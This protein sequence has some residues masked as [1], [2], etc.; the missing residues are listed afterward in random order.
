MKRRTLVLVGAAWLAVSAAR[1]VEPATLADLSWFGGRWVDDAGGNL[2]EETWSA[3]AGDSMQGMWRYVAGGKVRI[4]EILAIT[5]E[6]GGLV[7]RLRHFDAKL[8]GR[9]DKATP[10]ELKLV[11]WKARQASFEGPAVGAS[12]LVRLS[13]ARPSDDRLVCTLEK[14][15]KKEDF[16][17]RR[18]A[19]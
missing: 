7:L 3:P 2:S 16:A 9:E 8:V 5:A 1:A 13:Y 11:S 15:G 19:P 6:E 10:L 17:F 4:Y 14:D 18:A 12:G